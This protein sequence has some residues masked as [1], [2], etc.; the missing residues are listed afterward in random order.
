MTTLLLPLLTFTLPTPASL[1]SAV[2]LLL[3]HLS[4]TSLVLSHHPLVLELALTVLVRGVFF[5]A[6]ALAVSAL[7]GSGVLV[8]PRRRP[9]GRPRK[10]GV[11]PWVVVARVVANLVGGALVQAAVE[12]LNTEALSVRSAIR[13]AVT[14]PGV[15]ELLAGVAGAVVA[16]EVLQYAIHSQL[17]HPPHSSTWLSRLHQGGSHSLAPIALLSHYDHP[18]PYLLVHFLPTYLPALLLRPH[19]LTYLLFLALVS[20][21]EAL[22]LSGLR[23]L[24]APLDALLDAKEE[25]WLAG[26]TRAFADLTVLDWLAGTPGKRPAGRRDSMRRD[27]IRR[28]SKA[29]LA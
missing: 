21:F 6:P 2:S 7:Q 8:A 5:L 9:R 27:S 26:G 17:L 20:L 25:H 19:L 4:W 13:V 24:P 10:E 16:R 3:L 29:L 28:K 15:A 14:W 12:W 11:G 1:T 23:G 18:L 22:Q